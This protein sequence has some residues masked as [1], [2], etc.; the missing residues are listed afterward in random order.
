MVLMST[1]STQQRSSQHG[2]SLTEMLVMIFLAGLIIAISVPLTVYTLRANRLNGAARTV[3]SDIRLA[4]S[5]AATRAG[6]HFWQ[7]GPDAGRAETQWRVVRDAGNCVF[8]EPQTH[9]DGTEVVRRWFDL[10]Q[11]YDGVTIVSV[12]DH[13]DRPLGGVMF[14]ALGASVNTCVSQVSFP[15][16]VT[17]VDGAEHTRVI[18]VKSAGGTS[19]Q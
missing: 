11:S 18:V 14:D 7:W 3:L 6:I 16:Q 17:L 9:Q 19:L 5:M 12:R 10:A 4:Q 1:Y 15:I 13:N 2:F 8:P